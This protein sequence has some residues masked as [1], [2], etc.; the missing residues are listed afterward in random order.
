[1][2]TL[3]YNPIQRDIQMVKGDTLSFGFQIQGLQGVHPTDI[4]FTCKETPESEAA[5][6]ELDLDNGIDLRE[7]DSTEDV[8][9]YGLRLPPEATA[10]LDTGRYF[11]DLQLISGDDI[12]TLMIGRFAI[13]YEIT[14]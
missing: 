5:L 2:D 6:F 13:D 12:L 7:Y 1:M 8:Y 3:F 9:T 11:Y 14:V 4:N 10:D